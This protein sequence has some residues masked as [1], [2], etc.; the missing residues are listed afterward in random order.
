MFSIGLISF[1][2]HG[3]SRGHRFEFSS[4]YAAGNRV[5]RIQ[6]WDLCPDYGGLDPAM[7][8]HEAIEYRYVRA[9]NAHAKKQRHTPAST[10]SQARGYIRTD[11]SRSS[12]TIFAHKEMPPRRRLCSL[13]SRCTQT[14]AIGLV[15]RTGID[16]CMREANTQRAT[17]V[18]MWPRAQLVE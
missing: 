3:P 2:G 10:I 11:V 5:K 7:D 1:D 8:W 15:T 9:S 14:L 18:I 16:Q 4:H 12:G 17:R 13:P 6:I